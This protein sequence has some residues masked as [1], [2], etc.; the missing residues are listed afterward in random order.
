MYKI[1]GNPLHLV[2]FL[3]V[4][5]VTD[6]EAS[7]RDV[8]SRKSVALKISKNILVVVSRYFHV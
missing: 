5:G 2:S 3:P 1:G 7:D 6:V 8:V 4:A